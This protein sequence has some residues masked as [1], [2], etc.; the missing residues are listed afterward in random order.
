MELRNARLDEVELELVEPFETSFGVEKKRRFL[1]VRLESKDG[2]VGYGEC[3]A[4]SEPLYSSETTATARE[5]LS[6]RFL[7]LILRA[8]TMSPES[9]HAATRGYRGQRMAKSAV[10]TALV[11]LA[12]RSQDLSVSR[13]LGGRRTRVEVGVSV[14]IQPS[15]TA[16]VG[17]VGRYLE[18]GYRRV[19]LKVRPGW[20]SVPVRAVR[21]AFPDLEIWVDANQAY[22]TRARERIRTWAEANAVAQVEQPFAERAI[23]ASALLARGARFRLCLDES[24]VDDV[25]LEDALQAR[26]ITSLNVKTGRVGGLLPA[27][28]LARRAARAGFPAWVGG[29]LESGIGRAHNVHLASLAPFTLPA[30][31]SASDRYYRED[32]IER[33]FVLGAG[34]TLEVPKGPGLG[35]EVRE[36]V[37]RRARR[38]SRT[39]HR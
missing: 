32:L 21:Q 24:I 8:P 11:D 34:S 25:S 28:A 20:D 30:D 15:V 12:A 37:L 2:L 36:E 22:P 18:G 16:L 7:P 10:E 14:G 9:F 19:K 31:L 17:R 3:V 26:A 13:W 33:P 38:A 35:V 5:M 27:R 23:R 29:M 1:L 6:T 4:A 39:F